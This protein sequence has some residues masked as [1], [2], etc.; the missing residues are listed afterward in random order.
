MRLFRYLKG[1]VHICVRGEQPEKWINICIRRGIH[2]WNLERQ[3]DGS[4]TLCIPKKQYRLH[5]KNVCKKSGCRTRVLAR[6]GLIYATRRM[7]Y[8][9]ALMIAAVLACVLICF[10]NSLVW[11]VEVIPGERATE[12]D[13]LRTEHLLLQY[14]VRPGVLVDAVNKR[15]VAM[16]L[17]QAQKDLCWVQVRRTGT[18]LYV[19][20]E[21]GM[22]YSDQQIPLDTPCDLVAEKDFEVVKCTVYSGTAQCS[23]GQVVHKGDVLVS[24]LEEGVHAQADIVGRTWYSARVEI[25]YEA[26]Q[27][28]ETGKMEISRSFFLF[29]LRIPL[30][31]ASWLPWRESV[32]PESSSQTTKLRYWTLPG[33]IRLPV[34]I[35]DTCR[36][37]TALQ[38]VRFDEEE[39]LAYARMQATD[40][41][42]AKIPDNAQVLSTSWR[43]VE[44]EDGSCVYEITA[45]C[46]EPVGL[47]QG[48]V[49]E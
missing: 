48:A 31:G 27:I 32:D 2:L 3:K 19:E 41:L 24:G 21:R 49:H 5:T 47:Q 38:L 8:R 20:I 34:G 43:I 45:E 23:P 28:E 25:V 22:F 6:K 12:A 39:A 40:L 42:D 16:E 46:T 18:K 1:Y 30:P 10:L 37:E 36:K 29:G 14:G 4:F 35:Q 33:D 9:K 13:V 17:L 7:K 26:E 44:H 15:Q 11:S